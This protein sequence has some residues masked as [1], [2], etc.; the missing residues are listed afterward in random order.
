[1][2]ADDPEEI[3]VPLFVGLYELID[4]T[5]KSEILSGMF[6]NCFPKWLEAYNNIMER[7][8]AQTGLSYGNNETYDAIVSLL[9]ISVKDED[10]IDRFMN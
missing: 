4:D 7:H 9:A 5:D 6:E 8:F 1:M 2:K 3:P 10:N